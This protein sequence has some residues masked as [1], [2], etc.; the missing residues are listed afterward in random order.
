MRVPRFPSGRRAAGGGRSPSGLGNK[1]AE[2]RLPWARISDRRAI[3]PEA[4]RMGRQLD[5]VRVVVFDA[6]GTLIYPDP[7][8][9]EV[10]ARIGRKYGSRLGADTVAP[11]FVAAFAR[12]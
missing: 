3:F 2:F 5:G 7:A 1:I 10:Y 11:R 6:V 4:R 12:Q 9:P 8:A